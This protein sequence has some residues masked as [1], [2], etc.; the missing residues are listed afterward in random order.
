MLQIT[1]DMMEDMG[2]AIKNN[3]IKPAK[4]IAQKDDELDENTKLAL[5]VAIKLIEENAKNSG[6]VLKTYTIIRRIERI[7]D[8][9]KNIGEEVVFHLEGK[10][11]KHAD[12]K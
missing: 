10:V 1:I 8:Y 5:K 4:K 2:D 9:I 6:L 11:T 3:N 7:G 12:H